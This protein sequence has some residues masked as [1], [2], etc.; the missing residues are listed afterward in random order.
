MQI[1]LQQM[2]EETLPFLAREGSSTKKMQGSYKT[3]M[4]FLFSS[5]GVRVFMNYTP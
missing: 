4:V 5:L 2:L 3:G 1:H